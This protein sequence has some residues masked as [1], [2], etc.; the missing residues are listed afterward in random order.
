LWP[1]LPGRIATDWHNAPRSSIN[2]KDSTAVAGTI[3]V[4]TDV[5]FDIRGVDFVWIAD[6]LRL[7]ETESNRAALSA[8]LIAYEEGVMDMLLLDHLN[9][10]DFRSVGLALD[11]VTSDLKTTGGESD[12]VLFLERLQEAI[13]RDSRWPNE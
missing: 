5:Q 9:L 2:T 3:L 1:D 13:H 4:G 12:L 7:R 11:E 8:A 6:E 10:D